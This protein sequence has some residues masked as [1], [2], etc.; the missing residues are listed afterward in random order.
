MP[1]PLPSFTAICA[2]I[3]WQKSMK[4][5]IE[6]EHGL[7]ANREECL[8]VHAKAWRKRWLKSPKRPWILRAIYNSSFFV[9]RQRLTL[10]LFQALNHILWQACQQLGESRV[11]PAKTYDVHVISQFSVGFR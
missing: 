2:V 7:P 9:L 8:P 4:E 1:S 11:R 5:R 6:S 10:F 3:R